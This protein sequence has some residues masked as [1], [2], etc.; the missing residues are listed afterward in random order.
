MTSAAPPFVAAL[1]RVLLA[2]GLLAGLGACT[3]SGTRSV[4]LAQYDLGPAQVRMAAPAE[5]AGRDLLL[6]VK[7]PLW[8]QSPAMLYRLQ[9]DDPRR[10][11]EYAESRWAADPGSLVDSRLQQLL[12]GMARRGAERCR[13]QV[14]VEEFSQT[15]EAPGQSVGVLQGRMTLHDKKRKLIGEREFSIVQP[16]PSADARG[17]AHALTEATHRLA[18][19]I[20]DWVEGLAGKGRLRSCGE[21]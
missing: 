7:T 19:E 21:S 8:L 3:S 20:S 17:A 6:E 5:G 10:L 14:D 18:R 15:F 9:Y 2:A 12:G 11:R 13:L 16:S 1:A 4:A